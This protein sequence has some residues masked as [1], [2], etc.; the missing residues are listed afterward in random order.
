VEDRPTLLCIDDDQLGLQIR[1]IVLE[2]A[3]FQVFTATD[4][5]SGLALFSQH[6]FH[7]VILDFA[8]P[9]MDGGQ[10]AARMRAARSEVPILLLSAYVDLPT[11]VI[12][13][14][15]FTMMKGGPAEMLI[16]KIQEMLAIPQGPPRS[17]GEPV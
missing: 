9:G 3:G 8:M 13:S 17:D 2:C 6:L 5:E 1:Q 16:E 14:V 7:A 12:K 10:V 15:N 4:G 11:E